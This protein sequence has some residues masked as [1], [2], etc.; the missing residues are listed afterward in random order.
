VISSSTNVALS[1]DVTVTT[2]LGVFQFD[3]F[4]GI[5]IR[6]GLTDLRLVG[7]GIS[8][9]DLLFATP[10]AGSVIGYTGGPL[11]TQTFMLIVQGNESPI[12]FHL[13]SGS[14]TEGNAEVP[15]PE[16]SVLLLL[17]T[18]IAGVSTIGLVKRLWGGVAPPRGV[19]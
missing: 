1:A 17:V 16:P 7:P 12:T 9:L 10:T 11:S 18:A 5:L 13:A 3:T 19:T 15:V 2:L 14:L 6:H 8:T 4:D